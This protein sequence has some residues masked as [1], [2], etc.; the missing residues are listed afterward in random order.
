MTWI[1][2][3]TVIAAAG[4]ALT[5][6]GLRGRRVD[7]HPLCRRCG[8]DLT[9]NPDA[10]VCNECGADLTRKKAI[11]IGHRARRKLPLAAGLA[12]LVPCLVIAAIAGYIIA[13]GVDV[14]AYK[15]AWLL[16]RELRSGD[17]AARDAAVAEL[18]KR[19]KADAL[20]PGAAA[21]VVEWALAMQA[22][23]DQQWDVRWG[24]LVESARA[25]AKASD[26]QWQRYARQGF[27]PEL[28]VRTDVRQGDPL[29]MLVSFRQRL[30][31]VTAWQTF[32][33]ADDLRVGGQPWPET[34]HRGERIGPGGSLAT[35]GSSVVRGDTTDKI[36][37]GPATATAHVLYAVGDSSGRNARLRVPMSLDKVPPLVKGE[38][39]L[40]ADFAVR[41]RD[42]PSNYSTSDEAL[43]AGVEGR[44]WVT[45]VRHAGGSWELGVRAGDDDKQAR[46]WYRVILR[47][48]DGTEIKGRGTTSFRYASSPAGVRAR[49]EGIG[50]SDDALAGVPPGGTVTVIL[51]P[52]VADAAYWMDA[53]PVWGRDVVFENV[54]V[55]RAAEIAPGRDWQTGPWRSPGGTVIDP[56]AAAAAAAAAVATTTQPAA[57]P[58]RVPPDGIE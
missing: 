15:P 17:A 12:V 6:L 1:A 40:S 33:V 43:R 2:L 7:D 57:P 49:K 4:L 56:D 46:L 16:S 34:I 37:V 36:A 45:P 28:S 31:Y 14:Q 24:R 53:T 55:E 44:A 30:G 25:D 39:T 22:D 58:A 3:L 32:L 5:L 42:E 21:N 51:R 54:P 35:D 18:A 26:E 48:P 29:L 23:R 20:S 50:F 11:R 8:F 13:R 41:G 47:R 9:G 38:I 10:A 27:V 52:N 19:L